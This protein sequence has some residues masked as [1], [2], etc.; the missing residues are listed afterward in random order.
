MD[1]N[2]QR[3]SRELALYMQWVERFQERQAK[4]TGN[5]FQVMQAEIGKVFR[6]EFEVG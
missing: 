5:V 2:A 3:L 1:E 6:R 4:F